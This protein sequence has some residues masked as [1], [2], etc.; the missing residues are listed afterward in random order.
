MFDKVKGFIQKHK[1]KA[2]VAVGSAAAGMGM[3]APVA[4]AEE[5]LEA[6]VIT[7]PVQTADMWS[8]ITGG[9]GT[10]VTGV[11]MPVASF[12]TTN[13]ICL[14]FLTVTLVKLGISVLRRS[15]GAFGRGR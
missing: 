15:I 1:T 5:N 14:L 12:C 8:T 3:I 2:A 10:F 6:G 4:F 9:V 7:N 11:L 13:G